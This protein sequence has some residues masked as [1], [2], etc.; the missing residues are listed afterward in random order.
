MSVPLPAVGGVSVWVARDGFSFTD[1]NGSRVRRPAVD[2][3]DVAEHLV[4][5]AEENSRPR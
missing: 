3:N 5:Q 2:L 1:P 4:R